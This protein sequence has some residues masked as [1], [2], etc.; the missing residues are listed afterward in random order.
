MVKL[1][2]A[3]FKW[4]PKL[5]DVIEIAGIHPSRVFNVYIFGSRVYGNYDAASDWDIIM[6]ANN[7]VEA[8]ELNKT[9]QDEYSY[10][11][12]HR[13]IRYNIH[14]YT[15]DR[16]Q[17]DLDWHRMNNLECIFAP[18]WAKLKEDKK[19]EFKL[20]LKKLRHASSHISSNS[21]VKCKKKLLVEGEYRTAIKS[22]F[23]SIRI[24]MFATQIARYGKITDFTIANF[25]WRRLMFEEEAVYDPK[26]YLP[27]YRTIE[28][29]WNWESLNLEFKI[30]Y[31][32]MLSLF[33]KVTDK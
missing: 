11:M 28:R 9:V 27:I 32:L 2:P 18:D 16:F 3:T 25:I 33:R 4:I 1:L 17:K 21:W 6:V 26:T 15:P 14:V 24:P 22:F 31:N 5:E 10:N 13:F 19:Y 7:S 20:D 30:T 8:V 23:H 12:N 29:K